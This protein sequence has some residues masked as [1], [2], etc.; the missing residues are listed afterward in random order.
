MNHATPWYW[1]FHALLLNNLYLSYLIFFSPSLFLFS[2]LLS[3]RDPNVA[4]HCCLTIPTTN[5]LFCEDVN[6]LLYFFFCE[7]VNLLFLSFFFV[8]FPFL[9]YFIILLSSETQMSLCIIAIIICE[10]L[11]VHIITQ[12]IQHIPSGA[13]I[14]HTRY[15]SLHWALMGIYMHYPPMS[16][17]IVA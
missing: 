17:C 13:P 5:Y 2:L 9:R 16:L 7:D 12:H 1:H 15:L 14:R 8:F 3:F 6:L 11:N 4:M 10:V